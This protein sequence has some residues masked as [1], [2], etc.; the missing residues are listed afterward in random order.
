MSYLHDV[1]NGAV[2]GAA[3]TVG[4]ITT[5]TT[6]PVFDALA[7]DGTCNLLL[8]TMAGSL[9]S[10]SAQVYQASAS[11]GTYTTISSATCAATTNGMVGCVFPRD[12]RYLQVVLS[13]TGTTSTGVF[14]TLLEQKKSIA[15]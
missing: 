15:Y 12:Y 14:A 7:G 11:T 1:A 8:G 13:I 4:N 6:G 3:V 9:V 10:L 5:T 2:Y